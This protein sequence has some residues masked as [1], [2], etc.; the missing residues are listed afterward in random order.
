MFNQFGQTM[1]SAIT[2]A[3]AE[4]Q[5]QFV[6][7]L[8]AMQARGT[9]AGAAATTTPTAAVFAINPASH[10]NNTF[11][12]F[13]KASDLKIHKNAATELATKCDL[14]PQKLGLFMEQLHA[15]A[16][17]SGWNTLLT[18][19]A[20]GG[21]DRY[22]VHQYGMVT[23]AHVETKVSTYWNKQDRLAQNDNQL[24][25][26]L[27]ASMTETAT[28][29]LR[30]Q[31]NKCQR[32]GEECGLYTLHTIIE[33]ATIQAT[34][35]IAVLKAELYEGLKTQMKTKN[36]DVKKFNDWVSAKVAELDARG[37]SPDEL[38]MFLITSY[39]DVPD[40][41][42][43]QYMWRVRD[44]YNKDPRN[45]SMQEMMQKAKSQ[46]DAQVLRDDWLKQTEQEAQII[47]LS[48]RVNAAEQK[49]KSKTPTDKKR[50]DGDRKPAATSKKTRAGRNP[51][52]PQWMHEN[53]QKKKTIT[54][55][56]KDWNWCIFHG[57]GQWVTHDPAGG[58]CRLSKYASETKKA[59]AAAFYGVDINVFQAQEEEAQALAAVAEPLFGDDQDSD[60]SE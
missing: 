39:C 29:E 55:D 5:A 3:L 36:Y 30:S 40:A 58:K 8:Q 50:K 23:R 25:A 6:Q 16:Q 42:F 17:T 22:I 46:Y 11:L 21:Q 48:A 43:K 32:N 38:K 2:R 4:Q 52:N 12:D 44:E 53:P 33:L 37:D 54:K 45:I 1:Q 15:K 24:L 13:S 47:A 7:A 34:A 14:A 57:D 9:T 51:N 41:E 26:C 10:N 59:E 49:M 20:Q 60:N 27:K 18:M 31:R 35:Q 19:K 56:G 28:M